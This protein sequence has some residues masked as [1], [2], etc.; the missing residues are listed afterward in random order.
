MTNSNESSEPSY[1]E[2]SEVPRDSDD[3]VNQLQNEQEQL[4]VAHDEDDDSY[5]EMSE[6][7]ADQNR[8]NYNPKESSDDKPISDR[9]YNADKEDDPQIQ[10]QARK[11][12]GFNITGDRHRQQH[13]F[14]E[15]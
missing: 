7:E 2:P 14:F 4:E 5:S 9:H 10:N 6:N 12:G 15:S 1:S 3:I 11:C 8:K 13:H